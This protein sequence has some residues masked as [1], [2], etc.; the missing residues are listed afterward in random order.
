MGGGLKKERRDGRGNGERAENM[1][2][3]RAKILTRSEK[4]SS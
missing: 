3:T 1:V 2:G 4:W